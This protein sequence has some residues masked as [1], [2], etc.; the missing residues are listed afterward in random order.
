M[1]VLAEPSTGKKLSRSDNPITHADLVAVGILPPAIQR[2][3][4]WVKK[5]SIRNRQSGFD[6]DPH[7]QSRPSVVPTLAVNPPCLAFGLLTTFTN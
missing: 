1:I 3:T 6:L 7:P 2:L 5:R 4:A